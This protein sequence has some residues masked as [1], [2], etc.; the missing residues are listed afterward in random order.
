[1][2]GLFK[3]LMVP[4]ARYIDVASVLARRRTLATRFP[5]PGAPRTDLGCLELMRI[6]RSTARPAPW[7]LRIKPLVKFLCVGQLQFR[8]NVLL[9]LSSLTV[10]A[11]EL[12]EAQ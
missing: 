1:M 12:C 11:V 5:Q 3:A 4:S 10:T 2:G 6:K 9:I 8:K 7:L